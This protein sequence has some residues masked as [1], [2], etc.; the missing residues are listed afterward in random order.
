M[1]YLSPH[2]AIP[3]RSDGVQSVA[4]S[5]DGT[6]L[7]TGGWDGSIKLW[8]ARTAELVRTLNETHRYVASV[9]FSPDGALLASYS[10]SNDAIKLWDTREWNV[11]QSVPVADPK[12]A[13]GAIV[14]PDGTTIAIL[15]RSSEIELADLQRRN[16]SRSLKVDHGMAMCCAFSP[17][18]SVL[19][20][21][22]AGNVG[23]ARFRGVRV[24]I[25][26][27]LLPQDPP[28]GRRSSAR[29]REGSSR[30]ST[31]SRPSMIVLMH[32]AG[33]HG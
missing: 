15:G 27:R 28:Y 19:V 11:R 4:F 12:M 16:R 14:W 1:T 8:D 7:A 30:T 20:V 3:A 22:T 21:G 9:S 18:G 6:V 13:R 2:R 33:H 25:G 29:S 26:S 24:R 31:R 5:P 23:C 32:D 10:L 17:D